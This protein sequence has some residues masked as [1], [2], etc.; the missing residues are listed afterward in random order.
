MKGKR[1]FGFVLVLL[2]AAFAAVSCG[3]AYTHGPGWG[4]HGPG[5]WGGHHHGMTGWGQG[6]GYHGW[7]WSD[8]SSQ[9]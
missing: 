9:E 6:Y 4:P 3:T 2:L 8:R 5:Y 7:D 1:F